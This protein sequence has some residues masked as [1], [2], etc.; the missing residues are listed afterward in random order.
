MTTTPGLE[1]EVRPLQTLQQVARPVGR[2]G[3][4]LPAG[5][6]VPGSLPLLKRLKLKRTTAPV[7]PLA[8]PARADDADLRRHSAGA[9]H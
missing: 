3:G 4:S 6:R 8:L 7:A 2:G 9:G 5:R 1:A